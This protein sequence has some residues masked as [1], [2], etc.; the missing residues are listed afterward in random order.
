MASCQ[1][2]NSPIRSPIPN[3]VISTFLMDPAWNSLSVSSMSFVFNVLSST[4][5]ISHQC[6]CVK[7]VICI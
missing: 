3:I 6:F 2:L 5:N 7:Y 4:D 1:I